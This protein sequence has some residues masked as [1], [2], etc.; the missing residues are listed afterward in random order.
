MKKILLTL[1]LS[2]VFFIPASLVFATATTVDYNGTVVQPL[3]SQRIAPIQANSFNATNTL[4]TSTLKHT[5]TTQLSIGSLSGILQAVNGFV[6]QTLVNLASQVTGIL[7]TANGGTA[8]STPLGGILKGNGTG[9]IN[10]AIGDTDYQK[11]ISL[12]TSGTSGAAT[13]SADVLNIPNY[14]TGGG[15]GGSGSVGTSTHETQGGL[16]Y[17]TTNSA[18]PALVGEVA[19]S[20]VAASSPL[21]GSITVIGS[22]S[23]GIQVANTS[24]N[25]YLTSTDWNTFNN[26]QS[27]L[28]FSTGLT[29][30]T[31]TITVNTSQNIS[32]LSNLSVAGFVQTT[33]GGV[34]SSATLTSGQVTTALGFTP[35]S[36]NQTITLSGVVTGSGSTAI[37]TAFGSQSAGVLGNPATGNTAVQATSTLYGAVQ[38]GKVLAGVNG[39][40]QYVA[41]TT[42]SCSTGITCSYSGGNNAF[43]IANSAITDAML[44]STFVKTLTVTTANGISGSFTAGATPVLSLTLGA[45]TGVTSL[46]GL[47]V[48]ANTGVITTGTWNGTSIALANGGTGAALSGAN[49]IP[50]INAANTSMAVQNNFQYINNNGLMIGTAANSGALFGTS[51]LL[52][53]STSTN[54]FAQVVLTNT[55]N[56]GDASADF[57]VN[58]DKGTNTSYFGDFGINSSG[59]ANPAFAGENPGD[60]FLQSSDSGLNLEI[61]S[62]SQ[63]ATPFNFNVFVGGLLASAK[64]FIVSISTTTAQTTLVV[65]TTSPQAFVVQDSFGLPD[66]W[67]NTASSTAGS[68]AMQFAVFAS[69]TRATSCTGT[70]ITC[71]FS[72]DTYGHI[73]ASSTVPVLSSC[74]TTPTLTPDSSDAFGTIT[75]GSVAATACTLTFGVPHTIGTHCT[76]SEQTGSI[77]N[78]GSYTESLTGFTYSQTGLT[79]DKLD[80]ICTGQ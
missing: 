51:T 80:Y 44:A 41:T 22:G 78:V 47:V 3:F 52:Q 63:T 36:A 6:Q 59:Y 75:V 69:T 20:S 28:T 32:T 11:P 35:I 64:R 16:A 33:S 66:A 25:G 37:T 2:F 58:N 29:N 34:L 40:L 1:A 46:N 54:N 76:I 56:A 9:A 65:A 79:S 23:L 10:S 31:G 61:A 43:T 77:T 5:S 7:G 62:T 24:Q 70:G 21:T 60:V 19:T 12:T 67:V 72:I 39:S 30:T 68:T 38:P 18:T 50:F 13:F 17:F 49:E 15:G 71:L 27:A 55:S 42:D 74:G 45:L 57:V 14:A 53:M 4:A 26:K 8:S 48:T 73:S